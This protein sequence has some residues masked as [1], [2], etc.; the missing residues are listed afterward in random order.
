MIEKNHSHKWP[1]FIS[2]VIK[3]DVTFSGRKKE[4]IFEHISGTVSEFAWC[5][6]LETFPSTDSES[7]QSSIFSG[8][9]KEVN[10]NNGMVSKQK[11]LRK[12]TQNPKNTK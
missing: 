5:M 3:F 8:R 11:H 9:R 4:V 7:S 6:S 12:K 10:L 2:V 1:I